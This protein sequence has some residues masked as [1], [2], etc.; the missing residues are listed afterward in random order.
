[1]CRSHV[2]L[3]WPGAGSW[4]LRF[5]QEQIARAGAHRNTTMPPRSDLLWGDSMTMNWGFLAIWMNVVWS[6]LFYGMIRS[7]ERDTFYPAGDKNIVLSHKTPPTKNKSLKPG[8]SMYKSQQCRPVLFHN[9]EHSSSLCLPEEDFQ[10]HAHVWPRNR[11]LTRKHK[12]LPEKN[13]GQEESVVQS[14][15]KVENPSHRGRMSIYVSGLDRE[16]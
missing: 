6:K 3:K 11:I 15:S 2:A 1:M 7:F 16:A 5:N 13:N 4:L 9:W 8:P 12:F 10:H 14:K